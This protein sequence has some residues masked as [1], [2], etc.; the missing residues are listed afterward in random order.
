V[1]T[2]IMIAAITMI[3]SSTMAPMALT[4]RI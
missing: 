2:T 4:Q 1:N 3:T